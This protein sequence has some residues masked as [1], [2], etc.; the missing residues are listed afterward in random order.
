MVSLP[1][2]WKKFAGHTE[3]IRMKNKLYGKFRQRK[4]TK[5]QHTILKFVQ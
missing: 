1:N 5:K 2:V 4:S 3:S